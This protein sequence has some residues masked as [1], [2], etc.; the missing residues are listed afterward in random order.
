MRS[1][2]YSRSE[3]SSPAHVT[4]HPLLYII[5]HPSNWI[6][7]SILFLLKGTT[8]KI[9]C[10]LALDLISRSGLVIIVSDSCWYFLFVWVCRGYIASD[11]FRSSLFQE[12]S[13]WWIHQ[14]DQAAVRAIASQLYRLFFKSSRPWGNWCRF[15]QVQRLVPYVCVHV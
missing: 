7:L 13:Q 6:K 10:S 8:L 11:V 3:Q 12:K 5:A 1:A 2:L 14:L 15:K 9:I 4:L